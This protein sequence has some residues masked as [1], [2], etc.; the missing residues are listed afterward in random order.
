MGAIPD[1]VSDTFQQGGT[2]GYF[3]S[4]PAWKQWVNAI[5]TLQFGL[6]SIQMKNVPPVPNAYQFQLLVGNLI[7]PIYTRKRNRGRPFGQPRGRRPA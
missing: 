3:T 6:R 5:T 1:Q 7:Q 2:F 4:G